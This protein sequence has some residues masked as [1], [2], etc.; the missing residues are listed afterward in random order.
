MKPH[1]HAGSGLLVAL[2]MLVIMSLGAISLVRAVST[3]RMVAANLALRQAAVLA[4]DTATEAAIEWLKPL[5]TTAY[6]Y[7][8]QPDKGYY[9]NVPNGLDITGLDATES[10][11]A[12]DWESD[13]CKGSSATTCVKASP[14][15]DADVAGNVMRYTIHRLCR[16]AGS[17]Q[18]SANSCLIF[19]NNLTANSNS[20]RGQLSY[21]ASSRFTLSAAVY[22]RITVRTRG[23]RNTTVFTQTLIHF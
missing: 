13:G 14:V 20:K 8:D 7:A 9:A 23:P 2:V 22:Y 16:A 19:S 6:L 3:G 15:L 11:V 4:S 5:V 21:G 18:S 17:P 12:I 1:P 10:T